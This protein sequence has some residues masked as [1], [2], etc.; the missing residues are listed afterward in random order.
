MEPKSGTKKVRLDRLTKIDLAWLHF[1]AALAY[2][3]FVP[4]LQ[5]PTFTQSVTGLVFLVWAIV[6][7]LGVLVSV[8]GLVLGAQREELRHKGFRI[9]MI[10][11]WLLMAGPLAFLAVQVGLFFT[12]G[13]WSGLGMMFPYVIA[14]SIVARMMMVKASMRTRMFEFTVNEDADGLSRD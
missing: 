13:R 1:K 7:A 10:G 5:S 14:A 11:L 3:L 4:L 12:G 9:E 8:V 2:M 6:S